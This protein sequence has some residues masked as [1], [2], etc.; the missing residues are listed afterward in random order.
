MEKPQSG[1]KPLTNDAFL[2]ELQT[3]LTKV[4]LSCCACYFRS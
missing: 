4:R 1:R 2:A 3:A